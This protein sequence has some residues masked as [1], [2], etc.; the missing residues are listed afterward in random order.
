MNNNLK[1]LL[2]AGALALAI[3]PVGAQVL[4]ASVSNQAGD[5]NNYYAFQNNS[6]ALGSFYTS[7]DNGATS[8]TIPIAFTFNVAVPQFPTTVT[9]AA[10]FFGV[11]TNGGCSVTAGKVT[12]PMGGGSLSVFVLASDPTYGGAHA[13]ELIFKTTWVTSSLTQDVNAGGNPIFGAS[14]PTDNVNMTSTYA[15]FTHP[16]SFSFSFS[17]GPNLSCIGAGA[18]AQLATEVLGGNGNF[19]AQ[20]GRGQGVP[21]PGIVTMLLGTGV[22]ASMVLMRRRARK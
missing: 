1:A 22:A 16:E 12:Q 13:N 11:S 9:K 19:S 15:T 14:D 20:T 2:A 4:V 8:G 10:M 17:A 21:E 5:S 7:T 3:S 18:N 6:P